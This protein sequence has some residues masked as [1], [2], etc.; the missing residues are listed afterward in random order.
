MQDEGPSDIANFG[1]VTPWLARGAHPNP[2][3]FAW[4]AKQGIVTI[5][6][7]RNDDH[8]EAALAG[9]CGFTPV[10]IPVG[11]GTAPAHDQ[12]RA[13]LALCADPESRPLFVHCRGGKGRTSTFCMLVRL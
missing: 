6:N 8:T 9:V 10:H 1:W 5:V 11:D 7:L 3:G 4:L 13:W 2:A 12:A